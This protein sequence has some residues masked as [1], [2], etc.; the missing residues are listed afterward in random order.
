LS[1]EDCD[2]I[3]AFNLIM[4]SGIS[5][6]SFDHMRYTFQNKIS[7]NS[8]YVIYR[9]MAILSGVKP[10]MYDCCPNSCIAYTAKYIH[11]QSC[12]FCEEA[13]LN[14]DGKPRRQFTYFPLIPRLQG[15]FQNQEMIK[16]MSY[17][18]QYQQNPGEI[19][20]VFDGNHYQ[21][22]LRHRVVVDGEKLNHR[23]FSGSRNIALS[24][25]T[26]SYLL[27]KRQ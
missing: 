8:E 27:Y 14:A 26:D 7:I 12:P 24:L 1:D 22:L 23:Y 13:R 2:N 16:L 4:T 3:R 21:R 19:A 11:H 6:R 9:R 15:Y 18:A 20:D 25:S 10:V 5:R 17:R